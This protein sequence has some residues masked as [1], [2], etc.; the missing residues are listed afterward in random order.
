MKV[1]IVADQHELLKACAIA[2]VVRSCS[3]QNLSILSKEGG[4]VVRADL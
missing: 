4:R 3:N 1:E 2:E